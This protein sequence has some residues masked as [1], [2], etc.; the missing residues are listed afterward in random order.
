MADHKR[1]ARRRLIGALL[2]AA[3]VAGLAP[4]MLDEEA[5]P[6]SQDLLIEIPSRSSIFSKIET[7]KP[8]PQESTPVA[9]QTESAPKGEAIAQPE[10][11]GESRADA[12]SEPRVESKT[13]VKSDAKSESRVESRN[14]VKSEAKSETKPE[15]RVAPKAESKSDQKVDAPAANG[16]KSGGYLVQV[17]AYSRAESAN[18][19]KAKLIMGGHRVVVEVTRADDGTERHRVRIGPFASRDEALQVRDRAKAQGYEALLVTP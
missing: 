9:T 6:L 10:S 5:R 18:S 4:L 14:D 15:T 19:V 13:E 7:L 12:K 1:R 16:R 2:V 17:G 8:A 3:L 11:K